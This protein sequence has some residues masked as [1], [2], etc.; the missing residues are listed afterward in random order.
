MGNKHLTATERESILCLRAQGCGIRQIAGALN[1]SPS[2][3]SRELRRNP[4]RGACSAHEAE[5]LYRRAASA[6]GRLSG[7]RTKHCKPFSR[8]GSKRAGR[9]NRSGAGNPL[10]YPSPPSTGPCSSGACPLTQGNICGAGASPTGG[11]RGRMAG[12]S[13]GQRFHRASP[14]GRPAAA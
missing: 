9:R 6:A 5:K 2:T 4:V 11:K 3:I 1:R 13:Q 7:W 14:Q 8:P 12:A 10:Q